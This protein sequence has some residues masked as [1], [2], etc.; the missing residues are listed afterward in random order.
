MKTPVFGYIIM[1]L[2]RY[3]NN[4]SAI[5]YGLLNNHYITPIS[6]SDFWNPS[7]IKQETLSEKIIHEKETTLLPP[8]SPTKIIGVAMNYPG[9]KSDKS[10]METPFTFLKSPNSLTIEKTVTLPFSGRI[11]GE[12]ELGVV[13]SSRCK[14]I[15]QNNISSFILGYVLANDITYSPENDRDHHLPQS[16]SADNFCPINNCIETNFDPKNKKIQG[17][18]N[19]ILIRDGNSSSMICSIESLI[20]WLS[21]WITLEPGDLILTGCPG[22]TRDRLYIKSGDEYRVEVEGLGSLKTQFT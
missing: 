2:I 4:K 13:I 16:K 22:R 12:S 17:F 21:S 14:N 10:N 1:K 15:E 20:S 5:C 11:W 19:N 7:K 6:K 3:K 9:V 18:H 8:I